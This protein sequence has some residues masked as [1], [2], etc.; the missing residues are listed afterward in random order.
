MGNDTSRA[1]Y[2]SISISKTN[3]NGKQYFAPRNSLTSAW[4]DWIIC[5]GSSGVLCVYSWDVGKRDNGID[6]GIY[7]DWPIALAR[8]AVG[9][10][11]QVLACPTS[12]KLRSSKRGK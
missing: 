9:V 2:P 7:F 8:I 10:D 1:G 5:G 3:G 6:F 12:L 4:P 11:F